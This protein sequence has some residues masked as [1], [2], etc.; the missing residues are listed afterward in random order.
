MDLFNRFKTTLHNAATKE[1]NAFQLALKDELALRENEQASKVKSLQDEI[2]VLRQQVSRTSELEFELQQLRAKGANRSTILSNTPPSTTKKLREKFQQRIQ[3]QNSFSGEQV[4]AKSEDG[5]YYR[6]RFFE[7]SYELEK[8]TQARA[9]IEAMTKMWKRKVQDL[10]QQNPRNDHSNYPDVPPRPGSAP[11]VQSYQSSFDVLKSTV[12]GATINVH[13]DPAKKME[14]VPSFGDGHSIPLNAPFYHSDAETSDES[15][16]SAIASVQPNLA[17]LP[18]HNKVDISHSRIKKSDFDEPVIVRTVPVNVPQKRKRN[19]SPAGVVQKSNVIKEELLSSSPIAPHAASKAT[20]VQESIDLDEISGAIY[21]PRK[22]QTRRQQMYG[23]RSLSPS[24]QRMLDSR[25]PKDNDAQ[26]RVNRIGKH[27]LDLAFSDE[28][29]V[30]EVDEPEVQNDAYYKMLGEEHAARLRDA[31]R[32]KRA[33][34]RRAKQ[35]LHNH[36]Q[37]SRHK[38]AKHTGSKAIQHLSAGVQHE[39]DY[40]HVLQPTDANV[41]LPR[42][43]DVSSCKKQKTNLRSDH[44]VRYVQQLAE[45]GVRSLDT[46]NELLDDIP[47]DRAIPRR[48]SKEL[49]LST[50]LNTESRQRRLDE[51]LKRPSPDKPCLNARVNNAHFADASGT[52]NP[53]SAFRAQAT[54]PAVPRTPDLSEDHRSKKLGYPQASA[55]RPLMPGNTASYRSPFANSTSEKSTK[56][57]ET[58]LRSR[59]LSHLSL[60]DFKI[61][62]KHNQGYEYAFKE[63]VRKQDQ[64]KCLPGCTRLDCC[65]AI[66]RKMAETME[67]HFFHTSRLMGPSQEYDEHGILEDYLGD[68]AYRLRNMS[69][70]EKA[71]TLLQAKTKILADHYGKHR[72]IYAREPSPVGYWDVDMPDS[73][74]AAEIGRMAEI[75]TRQKVEERYREAMKQDGIWKFRDE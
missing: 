37:F 7:V 54:D 58:L 50:A 31:D 25:A 33:E 21:T 13:D 11:V 30:I 5:E 35:R 26:D 52:F 73:Q 70:E 63:V 61:N 29:K 40:T 65:G 4:H 36:R 48:L 41:V 15:D 69:R 42:T 62:P 34:K 72:E 67:N 75:R 64:R 10:L 68:Q 14:N 27:V 43:G 1:L 19:R 74:E 18:D 45:D 71:E 16:H 53:Y 22:D 9:I 57:H 23:T 2:D 66:F 17:G 8:V 49:T 24:I 46:E 60:N 28:E 12:A 59:P 51:L 44:G 39:V 20:G 47:Q 56:S 55:I 38:D 3:D 32:W 6:R